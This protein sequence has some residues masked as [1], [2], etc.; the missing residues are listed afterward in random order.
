MNIELARA[1]LAALAAH[2]DMALLLATFGGMLLLMMIEQVRPRRSEDTNPGLRWLVNWGIAG[3]NFFAMLYVA[4][5]L[6][7]GLAALSLEPPLAGLFETVPT[8]PAVAL[9][10]VL[11]EALSY[12]LHRLYHRVPALWYFHAVHHSDTVLDA[13]TSHRHHLG[14]VFLNSLILL[15]ALLLFG[16][17]V[18]YLVLVTL[19]RMPIVLW[20]H[21][22][23]AFPGPVEKALQRW[24]VTPDF[25]RIHHARDRRLADSNYGATVPWFDYLFG[26]ARILERHELQS[27][28]VGIGRKPWPEGVTSESEGRS[29]SAGEAAG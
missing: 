15:P 24:V 12:F 17:P 9:V 23:I 5:W 25:H 20:S 8:L 27:L 3:F 18:G 13:T 21:G 29:A 7:T 6:G 14:E 22:N 19:L 26:T 10:F 16:V 4:L 1:P 28:P 2:K 11:V